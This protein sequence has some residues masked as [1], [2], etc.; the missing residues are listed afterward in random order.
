MVAFGYS[1][2]L[3]VRVKLYVLLGVLALAMVSYGSV[4]YLESRSLGK[5]LLA[6]QSSH[7]EEGETG[8]AM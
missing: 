6:T 5:T 8:T 1:S 2:F 3:C 4:E 7:A